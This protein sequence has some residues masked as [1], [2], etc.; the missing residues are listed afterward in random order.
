M[1]ITVTSG[2]RQVHV[3][4]KG[5]STKK[6]RAAEN[7]ARRLLDAAP[8]TPDE[9]TPFGFAISTDTERAEPRAPREHQAEP[10]EI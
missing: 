6:L 5:K 1:R 10:Q 4:L 7:A 8:E 3:A 9:T 2:D